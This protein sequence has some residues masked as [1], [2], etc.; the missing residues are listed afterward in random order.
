MLS[1][2]AQRRHAQQWAEGIAM[3][4]AQAYLQGKRIL[5][6][7]D[8]IRVVGLLAY[9][10]SGTGT[11]IYSALD[12][13]DGLRQF[14]LHQ[15]HLVILDIMM[16]DLDGW[17]VCSRIRQVSD[18][19]I[20]ILSALGSETDIIHGFDCGA[21]DYVTK[22][23]KT[24]VLVARAQAALR[25]A[26]LSAEPE[27]PLT[28]GDEHLSIDLGQKQVLVKG[29]PVD[30]TRTE[31]RLLAYL[32]EHAGQAVTHQQICPRPHLPPASEA[33]KR[34]PSPPLPGDQTWGRLFFPHAAT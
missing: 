25:Q 31:Y 26:K 24:R 18:V 6:I 14:Y 32:V 2:L 10:F 33:G 22:P 7:E 9:C 27:K 15:P 30:L 21:V 16:P 34:P 19:P 29:T 20:I 12:G 5:I 1:P 28:Y 3:P 23:F 11:Q 17:Q 4:E 8:D 13:R